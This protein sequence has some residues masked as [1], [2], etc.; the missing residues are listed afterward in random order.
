MGRTRVRVLLGACLAALAAVNSAAAQEA[1][2][3]ALLAPRRPSA[4]SESP[5]PTSSAS[6]A[7]TLQTPAPETPPAPEVP[8]EPAPEVQLAPKGYTGASPFGRSL[9]QDDF[10]PIPDRWRIGFP[11]GYRPETG[12]FGRVY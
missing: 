11:T 2:Q 6:D 8:Y 12:G 7:M 4:A 3:Y 9:A 5:P 1:D 10:I